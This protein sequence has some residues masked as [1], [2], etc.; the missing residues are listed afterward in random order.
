MD[1]VLEKEEKRPKNE[2]N[3]EKTEL[4]NDEK[5]ELEDIVECC[6]CGI[7]LG[8]P[9]G[10]YFV[11]CPKCSSVTVTSE[12]LP[13]NCQFCEA[14]SYFPKTALTVQCSCGAIFKVA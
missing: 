5:P 8:F 9:K 6:K 7:K 13:L 12:V 2:E 11:K 1:E 14:L 4:N 3:E 10:S